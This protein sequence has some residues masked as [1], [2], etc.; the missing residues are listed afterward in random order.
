MREPRCRCALL[1]LYEGRH[2]NKPFSVIHTHPAVET[3]TAA[4]RVSA[5]ARHFLPICCAHSTAALACCLH[6]PEG[7][8]RRRGDLD[9]LCEA[10]LTNAG[11]AAGRAEAAV[12]RV[13][14]A[15]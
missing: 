13:Q 3:V 1:E 15:L 8:D 2:V 11:F 9:R 4:R 7:H 10:V 6:I 5:A 14:H 12:G